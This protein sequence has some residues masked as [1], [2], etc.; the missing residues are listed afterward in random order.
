MGKTTCRRSWAF[1]IEDHASDALRTMVRRNFRCDGMDYQL[2]M[3]PVEDPDA[4]DDVYGSKDYFHRHGILRAISHAATKSKVRGILL[5]LIRSKM[6]LAMDPNY[7]AATQVEPP[8]KSTRCDFASDAEDEGA[9]QPTTDKIRYLKPVEQFDRYL[10]YCFK[11]KPE[12]LAGDK[13]AGTVSETQLDACIKDIRDKRGVINMSSLRKTCIRMWNINAWARNVKP[14]AIEW[15]AATG[16][17][18]D[19][20]DADPRVVK[21]T[22]VDPIGECIRVVSLLNKWAINLGKCKMMTRHAGALEMSQDDMQANVCMLATLN[23]ICRRIEKDGLPS[24]YFW[25]APQ[26]GKSWLFDSC[27]YWKKVPGDAGGV[28]RFRLNGGESGLLLDDVKPNF[29]CRKDNESTIRQ[30][31]LG[32]CANV[33]VHSV[34]EDVCA[35]VLITSNALPP[36]AHMAGYRCSDDE[37]KLR[38]DMGEENEIAWKRRFISVKFPEDIKWESVDSEPI[39]WK[40]E[41][42][43]RVIA[44]WWISAYKFATNHFAALEKYAR[45]VA[46]KYDVP[47]DCGKLDEAVSGGRFAEAKKILMDEIFK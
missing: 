35:W 13:K 45:H 17:G 38:D 4:E 25:G 27:K 29:I 22:K 21:R 31:A 28:G 36:F 2:W 7:L 47:D 24:L 42:L 12:L 33:K 14:L 16:G 30:L 15:L 3:G 20:D 23:F 1:T 40:C 8:E 26:T 39:D 43:S 18:S 5:Q 37:Q 46:L 44:W 34:T 19:E 6:Q 41:N 10:V 9:A 32:N 11:E